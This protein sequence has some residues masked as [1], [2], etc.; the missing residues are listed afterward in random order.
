VTGS[1]SRAV[2]G[3]AEETG[4]IIFHQVLLGRNS[5]NHMGI[6]GSV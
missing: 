5:D 2:G 1:R 6:K 3:E 4:H